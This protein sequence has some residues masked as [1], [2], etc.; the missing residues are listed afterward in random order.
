[1]NSKT[2]VAYGPAVAE[3]MQR[4]F[5]LIQSPTPPKAKASGNK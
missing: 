3:Y 2:D 1:M 4:P 5:G